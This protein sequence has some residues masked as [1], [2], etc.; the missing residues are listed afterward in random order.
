M[1]LKKFDRPEILEDPRTAEEKEA[2]VPFCKYGCGLCAFCD[3]RYAGGHCSHTAYIS[4]IDQGGH[5]L[6]AHMM[7]EHLA[8]YEYPEWRLATDNEIANHLRQLEEEFHESNYDW[9]R[10]ATLIR[11]V[12]DITTEK[13]RLKAYPHQCIDEV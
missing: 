7:K 12:E 2:G 8:V 1:E 11:F 10:E 9:I 5:R 4:G 6:K 3:K 13:L